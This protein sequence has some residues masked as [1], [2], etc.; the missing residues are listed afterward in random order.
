MLLPLLIEVTM[1]ISL[2]TLRKSPGNMPAELL[3]KKFAA[4]AVGDP[5]N[6]GA[7]FGVADPEAG[8][9]VPPSER[10]WGSAHP[11]WESFPWPPTD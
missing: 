7:L 11:G 6:V 4:T 1:T 5:I 10:S 9:A 8:F 2:S 3:T